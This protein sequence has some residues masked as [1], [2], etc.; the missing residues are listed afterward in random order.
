MIAKSIHNE[1]MKL[2][3]NK[4]SMEYSDSG[5]PHGYAE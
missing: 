4:E 2:R 3:T 1:Q 5:V